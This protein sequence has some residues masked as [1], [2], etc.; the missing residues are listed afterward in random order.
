[1]L[2]SKGNCSTNSQAN[3]TGFS[4]WGVLSFSLIKPV[5]WRGV[6]FFRLRISSLSPRCYL[7]DEQK[8]PRNLSSYEKAV[9]TFHREE[10]KDSVIIII[11]SLFLYSCSFCYLLLPDKCILVEQLESDLRTQWISIIPPPTHTHK[12][13]VEALVTP[14]LSGIR[15]L[16][17]KHHNYLALLVLEAL[18]KKSYLALSPFIGRQLM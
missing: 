6:F 16:D 8:V 2:C 13:S 15:Y 7:C 10:P 5:C 11:F 9:F 18:I 4:V 1:M 14:L 17:L 12:F 3:K